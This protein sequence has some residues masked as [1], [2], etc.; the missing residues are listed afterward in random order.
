MATVLG[1]LQEGCDY[2]VSAP[3]PRIARSDVSKRQRNGQ[4]HGDGESEEHE[5]IHL[6]DSP[7]VE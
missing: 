5:L 2:A 7:P 6:L 3:S 1:Y 4:Q